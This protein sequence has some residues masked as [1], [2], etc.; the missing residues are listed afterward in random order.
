MDAGSV[1]AIYI[2]LLLLICSLIMRRTRPSKWVGIDGFLQFW[3]VFRLIICIRFICTENYVKNV[4]WLDINGF[5]LFNISNLNMNIY[6][7]SSHYLKKNSVFWLLTIRFLC[8]F[9]SKILYS[10]RLRKIG[11]LWL[12]LVKLTIFIIKIYTIFL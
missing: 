11:L 7:G 2:L 5:G 10:L 6:L 4:S 1:Y 12:F 8:H 9:L 3:G